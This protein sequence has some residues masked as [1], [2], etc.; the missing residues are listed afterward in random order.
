VA[1]V[2]ETEAYVSN[3]GGVVSRLDI[4]S[5]TATPI[6]ATRG[7]LTMAV[8]LSRRELYVSRYN[9]ASIDVISITGVPA[10][11]ANIKVSSH[12]LEMTVTPDGRTAYASLDFGGL[13][14]IDLSTRTVT[15]A[16]PNLSYLHLALH[17]TKPLI[18]GSGNSGAV[19]EIDL[20]TGTVRSFLPPPTVTVL[21]PGRRGD[22]RRRIPLRGER[23]RVGRGVRPHN[24]PTRAIVLRLFGMGPSPVA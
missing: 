13:A 10:V 1:V 23:T 15:T 19:H 8:S 20:T 24:R 17:P 22:L 18:Y 2:S 4:A 3:L 5:G 11:V 6:P 16:V 14:R 7:G 21:R 9:E 12:V